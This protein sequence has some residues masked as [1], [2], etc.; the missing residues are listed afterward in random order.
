MLPRLGWTRSV[1]RMVL[2]LATGT[3][4]VLANV[5]LSNYVAIL[6]GVTCAITGWL[7][8]HNT[9]SR[10]IELNASI[11]NLENLV[12]WWNSLTEIERAV[13]RNINELIDQG[14]EYIAAADA[15]KRSKTEKGKEPTGSD[16]QGQGASASSAQSRALA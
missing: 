14:E 4:A 3:S 5:K 12:M 11:M 7:E 9:E 2:L 10:V 13:V 6:S 15:E 8:F 16:S 1:L